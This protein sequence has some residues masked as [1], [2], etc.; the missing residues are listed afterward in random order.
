MAFAKEITEVQISLMTGEAIYYT[1]PSCNAF[2]SDSRTFQLTRAKT[3]E[4]KPKNP[5][6]S[7]LLLGLLLSAVLKP[8]CI[9]MSPRELPET[10][11]LGSCPARSVPGYW[12]RKLNFN[13]NL[14]DSE[15]GAHE[16]FFEK[17]FGN[18]ENWTILKLLSE[19]LFL[20]IFLF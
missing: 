2:S 3:K 8:L 4:N 9:Y 6:D 7:P 5:E 13:K 11:I 17:F 15:A 16:I 18:F 19:R 1:C 12:D 10:Q 14:D 20:A